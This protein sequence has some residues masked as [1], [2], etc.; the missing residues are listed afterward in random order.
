MRVS[1]WGSLDVIWRSVMIQ[2]FDSYVTGTT[3]IGA[4]IVDADDKVVS[5]GRSKAQA[6]R[7]AHAETNAIT[8]LPKTDPE[9]WL[10][11]F[12]SLEPCAYCTGALRMEKFAAVHFAAQ[13]PSAGCTYLLDS[14]EW[15]RAFRCEVFP[16][17]DRLLEAV[18]VALL[19]EHRMRDQKHRWL[20]RWRA[21]H[22]IATAA[23]ERLSAEG[24]FDDWMRRD[25]DPE[26]IFNDVASLFS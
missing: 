14:T 7:L 19:V 16:P 18:N 6:E 17:A 3:P 10:A 1:E 4:V 9:R 11:V 12:S 13:D 26:L 23:G 24:R 8:A 5:H 2:A 22:P 21:Y 15:F 25:A 20:E